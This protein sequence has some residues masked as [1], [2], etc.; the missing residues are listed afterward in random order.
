MF[1][2]WY[3]HMA[4]EKC[5]YIYIFCACL[6]FEDSHSHSKRMSRGRVPLPHLSHSLCCQRKHWEPQSAFLFYQKK[7][8]RPAL[9]WNRYSPALWLVEC[10]LFASYVKWWGGG[11]YSVKVT[12]AK[13]LK[14]FKE[15]FIKGIH[16]YFP[17]TIFSMGEIVL[18]HIC[19]GNGCIM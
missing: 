1:F 12:S 8:C 14:H 4:A 17:L 2:W 16:L 7:S 5:H 18:W 9:K 15:I 11:L 19:H 6:C 10:M 13:K 3:S